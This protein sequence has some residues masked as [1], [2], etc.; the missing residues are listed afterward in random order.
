[1]LRAGVTINVLAGQPEVHSRN[2]CRRESKLI[3]KAINE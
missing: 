1:V 2:C 3:E